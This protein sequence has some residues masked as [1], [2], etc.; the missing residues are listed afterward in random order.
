MK[1]LALIAA[2]LILT[3]SSVS[4]QETMPPEDVIM[5]PGAPKPPLRALREKAELEKK[6]MREDAQQFKQDKLDFKQKVNETNAGIR[7]ERKDFRSDAIGE[8]KAMNADVVSA[9]KNAS[10]TEERR[11]ILKG[12]K[13]DRSEFRERMKGEW[14]AKRL[15]FKGRR[16]A[17]KEEG[18]DMAAEHARGVMQR[19]LQALDRFDEMLGRIDSRIDKLEGEGADVSGEI[20]RASCRERV[21]L[22]V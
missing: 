6:Q 14:D 20:G 8:R 13:E 1:R 10:S 9:L 5:P 7:V 18:R 2:I 3:S 16:D 4:A 19:L 22:T 12:A 17:L 15:E 11:M 21:S